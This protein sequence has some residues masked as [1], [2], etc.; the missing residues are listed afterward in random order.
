[1]ARTTRVF[2][3]QVHQPPME[4]GLMK[5]GDVGAMAELL[6]ASDLLR[7]GYQVF[8]ACSP[9][10]TCDLVAMKDRSMIRVEVRTALMRKDGT[11]T[12]SV[13]ETDECDLY[14]LVCGTVIEYMKPEKA[15]HNI[16]LVRGDHGAWRSEGQ[17]G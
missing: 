12:A 14:A 15:K 5:P 17:H 7:Q 3:G 1:M 16:R 11:L 13:R 8:R 6:V 10:A 9:H 2:V 4:V